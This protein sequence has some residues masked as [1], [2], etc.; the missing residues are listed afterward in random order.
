MNEAPAVQIAA[1]QSPLFP[2]IDEAVL[3]N[4]IV[5]YQKLGCWTP[6]VEFTPQALDAVMDVLSI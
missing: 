4:C 1:N 3:A 6:H 2:N 5:T